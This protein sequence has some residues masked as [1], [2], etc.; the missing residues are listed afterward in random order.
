MMTKNLY[1]LIWILLA[2]T[3]FVSVLTG[4]LTPGALVV[5]SVVALILVFAL[6]FWSLAGNTRER[7]TE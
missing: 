5:Y 6:A 2:T 4:T 1:A 3:A 7:R